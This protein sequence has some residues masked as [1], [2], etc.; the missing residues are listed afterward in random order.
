MDFGR[1]SK[2][3]MSL[4]QLCEMEETKLTPLPGKGMPIVGWTKFGA[5]EGVGN[6]HIFDLIQ[7]NSGG[8]VIGGA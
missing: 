4:V 7:S 5:K 3:C 1:A 8:K 2:G 6:T